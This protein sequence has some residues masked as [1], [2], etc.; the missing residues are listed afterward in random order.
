MELAFISSHARSFFKK[1]SECDLGGIVLTNRFN[2]LKHLLY[3]KQSTTH[4]RLSWEYLKGFRA[5]VP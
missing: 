5:Q 2:P 1:I 3:N 4:T